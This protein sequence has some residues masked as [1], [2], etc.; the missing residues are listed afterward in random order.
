MYENE[1]VE[2]TESPQYH[3]PHPSDHFLNLSANAFQWV[4]GKQR[5][6]GKN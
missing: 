4:G 5:S 6:C 1:H 2:V 3:A